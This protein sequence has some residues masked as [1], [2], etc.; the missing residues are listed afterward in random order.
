MSVLNKVATAAVSVGTTELEEHVLPP[1]LAPQPRPNMPRK[2][3]VFESV[4]TA[5]SMGL[6]ISFRGAVTEELLRKAYFYT[7]QEH[8]IL[9]MGIV[10]SPDTGEKSFV[11][12]ADQ[13]MQLEVSNLSE[14]DVGDLLTAWVNEP[15]DHA[16][17]QTYFKY[18]P[19]QGAR[20]EHVLL[21]VANHA[22]IDGTGLL[23]IAASFCGYLG[24]LVTDNRVA[25][26]KSRDF[27]DFLAMVPDPKDMC[28]P[29]IPHDMLA[30]PA[31]EMATMIDGQTPSI[32]HINERLSVEMTR[33]LI[34]ASKAEGY[35][36]QGV[37]CAVM[38]MS[39][40]KSV[41]K[42]HPLPQK[43]S[44][45]APANMRQRMEP[46]LDPEDCVCGIAFL[47]WCQMIWPDQRL[48][49]VAA[50][51]TREIRRKLRDGFAFGF[52][53]WLRE[54]LW[55]PPSTVTGTTLGINPTKPQY[56]D[57]EVADIVYG[58]AIYGGSTGDG[59]DRVQAAI[60]RH[61]H[62][63]RDRLGFY[64][65]YSWPMVNDECARRL[66]KIEMKCLHALAGPEAA[67]ITVKEFLE[68][69][70]YA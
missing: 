46:S 56:G 8:P 34:Q 66:M 45:A 7:Q 61:F 39:A 13:R 18:F 28:K 38:I 24:E 51:A 55:M 47:W 11:E 15:R 67:T 22:G 54:D 58:G 60:V 41:E 64:F 50:T 57:L 16:Q 48:A 12:K 33:N 52:W 6:G 63:F 53:K 65:A 40:V 10:E 31:L 26:P 36:I 62:T 68:S 29:K 42:S 19:P 49:D 14:L 37:L 25:E 30:R 17:S 1:G 32:R 70:N 59:S 21:L 27:H 69:V 3:H 23:Y 20:A 5:F 2:L 43:V 9:R 35:T 4:L 44:C